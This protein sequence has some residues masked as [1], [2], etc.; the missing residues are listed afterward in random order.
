MG[1]TMQEVVSFEEIKKGRAEE[2]VEKMVVLK[3]V[4]YSKAK[5]MVDNYLKK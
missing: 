1:L 4:S 3:D 5:G 2:I